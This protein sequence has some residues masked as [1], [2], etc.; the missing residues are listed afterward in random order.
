MASTVFNPM[1]C[2]S[3]RELTDYFVIDKAEGCYV[4]DNEG[5]RYIDGQAGLWCVNAG[6]NNQSINEA[7]TNQLGKIAYYNTFENYLNSPCIELSEKLIS[8]LEPEGMSKVFYSSGGSD[9]I[10]SALKLAR[11]YFSN[12][13]L[14]EKKKFLSLEG[15]Y[16][17]LHFGGTSINGM[18]YFQEGYSPLLDSGVRVSYDCF[19]DHSPK[20]IVENTIRSIEAILKKE[21]SETICALIAEPIQGVGGVVIPPQDLWQEL[22]SICDQHN[23]LLIA[24]EVITGLGRSGEMFGVRNWNVSPDIMCLA[25]GLTSGYVPL[26]ATVI[27]KKIADSFHSGEDEIV[28][29]HGYTYSGHPLACATA[30]ANIAFVEKNQL[31][32]NAKEIG[33]HIVKGLSQYKSNSDAIE[34]IRGIGLM[35]AID[36]L[37]GYFDDIYELQ[38]DML[39]KGLIVRFMDETIIISPP[40]T[41]NVDTANDLLKILLHTIQSFENEK[42]DSLVCC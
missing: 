16:H 39:S 42:K 4:Y 30:L 10:E 36:F 20:V 22:R 32:T 38:N 18:D 8:M 12:I 37:P 28:F 9:S 21:G 13:G 26:G 6:H 17:G 2:P 11:K 15:G 7:I 1:S 41:M 14:S 3:D 31:Q 25:K 40:L 23:I 29:N 33:R 35:I 27:N 5:K 19:N 24:D 34:D